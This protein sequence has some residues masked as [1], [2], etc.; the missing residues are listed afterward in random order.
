MSGTYVR[1]PCIL[2]ESK[3]EHSKMEK[4]QL[5]QVFDD[6]STK[7]K[8]CPIFTGEHG[9][10]ALLYTEDRF[11]SIC[12]QLEFTDG[13]ELFDTFEEVVANKAEDRWETLTGNLTAQEKTPARFRQALDDFYLSYCDEDARDIMFQYLRSFKKPFSVE[14]GN[15]ADRMETLVNYANR[16]PGLE[17]PMNDDQI[18]KL[19]FES[20]PTRWQHAYIQSG[21]RIQAESLVR[22]VQYMKD[23]KTF[24][25]GSGNKRKRNDGHSQQSSTRSKMNQDGRGR[26][27]S[28]QHRGRGRTFRN[29][30]RTHNGQH[31]WSECW[32]NEH[33][34]NYRPNRHAGRG[35]RGR[36]QNWRG[37]R[38]FGR[39]N[40]HHNGG[41]GHYQQYNNNYNNGQAQPQRESYH[42]DSRAPVTTSTVG[43]STIS[44]H[45]NNQYPA[46]GAPSQDYAGDLHQFEL[47]PSEYGSAW[48]TGNPHPAM[49]GGRRY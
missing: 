22:V 2:Y 24:A 5:Q 28:Q 6:G 33:S 39:S 46:R 45:T 31:D 41:R 48:S 1:E 8:R 23:E 16:L 44:T 29:P 4:A 17:P 42:A 18:K 20:F 9:I 43:A 25:D 49:Q 37:G 36:Q 7:K 10:E 30:C 27:R 35:G 47:I 12:R 40:Y 21:R 26:G 11:N 14:A 38:G 13:A 34:V 3:F 32:D 15:H 19:I